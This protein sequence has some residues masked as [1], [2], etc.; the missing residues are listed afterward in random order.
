MMENQYRCLI[1][2][3][4]I[5]SKTHAISRHVKKHNIT[6]DEY[7]INYYNT[8]DIIEKC[9]FCDRNAVAKY[10]IDHKNLKYRLIYKKGFFCRTFECKSKISLDILGVEYDSKKFEKIGSKSEYLTKLYKTDI[11][12]AKNMK[13][14]PKSGDKIFNN[15]LEDFQKKYGYVDGK[16]RYEKRL[17]GIIKNHAGNKFS[18]TLESFINKYGIEKGTMAYNKRCE[19]ISYTSSLDFFINKYGKLEGEKIW[20]NKF[21]QVKTSK[22]SKIIS[23]ILEK[24][25]IKYSIEYNINGKFVDYYLDELGIAIEYF[26]DYWHMNPK[27]YSAEEYNSRIKKT[28]KEVWMDDN[29]RLNKI[30]EV[31]NSIII[32]WESTKIDVSF[33][34]KTINDIKNKKTIISL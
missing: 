32:I 23:E 24:L 26:G 12:T 9:G 21:K 34:E 27:L 14:S 2:N 19:K 7:I 28:A 8:D 17:E 30:K 11:E 31:C 13:Y 10:E 33:L 18:C 20:K 5:S 15:K 1:C 4:Y 6:L 22:S 16:Y 25:N 3:E 29:I